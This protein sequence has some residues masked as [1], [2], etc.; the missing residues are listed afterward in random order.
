MKALFILFIF[1]YYVSILIISG[2][3]IVISSKLILPF[4]IVIIY[5]TNSL[6]YLSLSTKL[7]INTDYIIYSSSSPSLSSSSLL[8][9]TTFFSLYTAL[10]I[11]TSNTKSPLRSLLE[12]S[13]NN[14]S[15][16]P[17]DIIFRTPFITTDTII[18]FGK[19]NTVSIIING[20]GLLLI[21]FL[22]IIMIY[23]DF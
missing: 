17:H 19:T 3:R 4:L 23:I 11:S 7:L 13:N 15:L 10:P 5:S 8:N 1:T 16:I 12:T 9:N 21:T 20:S 14:N 22:L 2:T 6:N 18:Q